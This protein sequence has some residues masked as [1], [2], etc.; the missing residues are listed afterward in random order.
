[1]KKSENPKVPALIREGKV[2]KTFS[3]STN[4]VLNLL[5]AGGEYSTIEL[6]ERTRVADQRNSIRDLRNVGIPVSDY[7]IE[8]GFTRFKMY[9]IHKGGNND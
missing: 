9:F 8:C 7:W 3:N 5:L 6:M 2:T 1:M 4:K